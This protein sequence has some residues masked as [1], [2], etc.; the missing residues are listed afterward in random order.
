M[1]STNRKRSLI[2]STAVIL[3]CLSIVVGMTFALFTDDEIVNNHLVA[4]N[5]DIKLERTFL[6]SYK[7]NDD[8]FLESVDD[9]SLK[10]FTND[11]DENVFAL[12]GAKIVPL[13]SYTATM[14][15]SNE[16]DV[17]FKYWIQIV[18][19]KGT[20]AE[21]AS[22]V[23]VS[24]QVKGE[25]GTV[26]PVRVSKGLLV[27]NEHDYV[28]VV[29]VGDY[30]EFDVTVTFVDDRTDSTINNND[31]QGKNLYFDLVVHAVQYTGADP[32]KT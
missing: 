29:G 30:S 31:A 12:D 20:D 3:L 6:K 1:R 7:L 11:K 10:E 27:G 8:G 18:A 21:L 14:K 15:V 23:D 32:D 25:N 28:A 13:S 24:V 9:D 5:L 26:T 19:T 22:Q 16:S 2:V 17:A 4:G